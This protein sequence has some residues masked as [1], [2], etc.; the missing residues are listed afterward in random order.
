LQKHLIQTEITK[1]TQLSDDMWEMSFISPEIAVQALQGQFIHV[2]NPN[3]QN[4]FLR[5]PFSIC[6]LDRDTGCVTII[7][8]VVGVGTKHLATM[9]EGE[10]ID[11]MGPL[12]N[13]FKLKGERPLVIGGGIGIAPLVLL[14]D[15]FKAKGISVA[16]LLGS[17]H[18]AE[19]FWPNY[20]PKDT[21]LHITTDDGSLGTKGFVTAAL[22]ELLENG[23]YDQIYTCGPEP[24]MASVANAAKERDIACQVSLERHMACGVGAC[25]SCACEK[26]D[27]TRVKACT[28]GPVFDATEI[29]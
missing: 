6:S 7:Y 15:E 27:G 17:R 24:L 18:K 21:D 20:F 9:Q 28:D 5:R 2:R 25:L 19:M 26:K 11:A 1:H 10:I 23:N 8:R 16:A 3:R 12:G 4:P 14:A 13:N 22:P 29:F